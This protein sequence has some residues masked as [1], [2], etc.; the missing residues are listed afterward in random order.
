[1]PKAKQI[2]FT[3]KGA[4]S[5]YHPPSAAKRKD[6]AIRHSSEEWEQ[7][8]SLISWLYYEQNRILPDVVQTVRQITGFDATPAQYRHQF[9]RWKKL[10]LQDGTTNRTQKEL[11][12]TPP[13][14]QF[15]KRKLKGKK[16]TKSD[17]IR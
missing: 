1:M 7:Y 13:I 2:R 3:E 17:R 14:I 11:M 9:K 5:I 15:D 6:T 12:N 10:E 4:F 8:K 16:A